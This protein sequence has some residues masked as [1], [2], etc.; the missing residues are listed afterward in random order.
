MLGKE[1]LNS[2]EL[3]LEAALSRLKPAGTGLDRDQMLFQAGRI[4]ARR[5]AR[6]WQGTSLLLG[7]FAAL[8]FFRQPE[9]QF[10]ERPVQMELDKHEL[11]GP[12]FAHAT[13]E[14]GRDD[15]WYVFSVD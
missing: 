7:V 12:L 10:V 2:A 3:E 1:K 11:E 15:Q 4:S 14:Y 13:L 5:R 8:L 9:P 6:F